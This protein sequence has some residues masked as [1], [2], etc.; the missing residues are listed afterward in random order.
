MNSFI[1]YTSN[2]WHS[3][4][5]MQDRF[6]ITLTLAP[7]S[8]SALLK[9]WCPIEQLIVEH[10]G[11]FFFYGDLLRMAALHSSVSLITS[12]VGSGLFLLK[13]SLMYLAYVG[14]YIVSSRGML[15]Y[16]F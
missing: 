8:Q 5:G 3:L 14:T 11:S 9:C 12:V 15:T 16:D 1:N 2:L 10:P 6:S 7:R 13:M 4:R